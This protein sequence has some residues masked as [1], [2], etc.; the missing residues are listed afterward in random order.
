MG[1]KRL[2]SLI[3]VFGICFCALALSR[4]GNIGESETIDEVFMVNAPY[5]PYSIGDYGTPKGGVAVELT[6]EIFR[7]IGTDV[8][9]E[10][11]PWKRVLKMV[12][13]GRADGITMLVRNAERER[14]LV[15][16]EPLF[17]AREVF[18]FKPSHLGD[19]RWKN[20]GDLKGL[21]IGLVSDYAYSPD[22]MTYVRESGLDV[23]YAA[24]DRINFRKLHAER[25]DLCLCNEAI[26]SLL[27]RENPRWLL[28]L[29]KAKRLV[30]TY[31]DYMA[32]GKKS[33][34]ARLVPHIDAAITE[35]KRDGT[36]DRI[37]FHT[38]Y[39]MPER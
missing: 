8:R 17:Q 25:L 3:A 28:D 16:T 22:F 19:F 23:E 39:P 21:R 33:P 35:M 6:E 2:Y 14:F 4:A 37:L 26:G 24:S 36:I 1:G 20:F 11:Y 32:F 7:R 30:R 38:D 10:L 15:F 9:I 29:Q 18:Y 31:P 5:P 27:M 13:H 34:A 12:K